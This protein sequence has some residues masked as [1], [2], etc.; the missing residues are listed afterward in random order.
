VAQIDRLIEENLKLAVGSP[1]L[2]YE[3]V[4]SVGSHQIKAMFVF[5]NSIREDFVN[6]NFEERI[7]TVVLKPSD[8]S[9]VVMYGHSNLFMKLTEKPPHGGKKVSRIYRAVMLDLRDPTIENNNADRSMISESDKANITLTS[10]QLIDPA[11]YELMLTRVGGSFPST[12]PIDIIKVILGKCRLVDKYNKQDAVGRLEIDDLDVGTKRHVTIPPNIRLFDLAKY[13]QEKYGVYSQGLGAY[14]KDRVWYVFPP[15]TRRKEKAD[16]WK[17]V[18]IN[19][20]A[21]RNRKLE[22]TYHV[23]G[24]TITIIMT[25]EVRHGDNTDQD[26]LVSGTGVRYSDPTAL[27]RSKPAD[28]TEAPRMKPKETMTEYNAVDYVSKFQN[29]PLADQPFTV[30]AAKQASALAARGGMYIAGVW[31]RSVPMVLLPGMAVTFITQD[32]DK[33][34]KLPGTLIGAET[35]TSNPSGGLIEHTHTSMTNMTLYVRDK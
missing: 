24:K 20:P 26:A 2:E 17:L 8:Y 23:R 4:L 30:N 25:G 29:A 7:C 22:R 33:I 32:G 1:D 34:K 3:A 35:L 18:I 12:A 11:V 19:A 28:G 13:L 14:L 27:L 5:S 10:F 31:E 16:A 6:S 21:N 15:F 9:K